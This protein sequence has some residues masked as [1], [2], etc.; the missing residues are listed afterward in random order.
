MSFF[1][2][3]IFQKRVM[4]IILEI[5][6]IR[7]KII[8]LIQIT[9]GWHAATT[10][11]MFFDHMWFELKSHVVKTFSKSM[12]FTKSMW[13]ES[14]HMWFELNEL[15]I[16]IFFYLL[17]LV[18]L[19]YLKSCHNILV[20]LRGSIA[21]SIG[22]VFHPPPTPPSLLIFRKRLE[23]KLVWNKRRSIFEAWTFLW[24][25]NIHTV[26]NY[27]GTFFTS[28][29]AG[30][31]AQCISR[32]QRRGGSDMIWRGLACKSYRGRRGGRMID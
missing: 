23:D 26:S 13:F 4:N 15:F 3:G 8:R 28:S 10:S 6:A 30:D 18:F 14:N 2:F 12:W 9:C 29:C 5:N 1:N 7:S 32:P 11:V 31:M 19:F 25:S 16:F 22:H 27:F 20:C 21:I 24:L 17:I